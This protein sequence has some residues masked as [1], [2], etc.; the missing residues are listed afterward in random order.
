MSRPLV[1]MFSGQGSQY[2]QM[3]REL[4]ERQP[5]YRGWML[6]GEEVV[7][8]I[9]GRSILGELYSETRKKSDPFNQVVCTHPA[10]FMLGYALARTLLEGG[11]RPDYLLGAS[12]GELTALCVA[13]CLSFEETLTLITRQAEFLHQHRPAGG[14]MLAVFAPVS[15]YE[16]SRGIARRVTLCAVYF[17]EAFVV[18]GSAPLLD[19][20]EAELTAMSVLYQRLPITQ[21]FHSP[22]IDDMKGFYLGLVERTTLRPA[23]I[24]VISCA[25]AA[26]IRDAS[27]SHLWDIIRSPIRFQETIRQQEAAGSFDYV[28]LGPSGSLANFVKYN[29]QPGSQS[30]IHNL[31]TPFG[32][33]WRNLERLR[34]ELRARR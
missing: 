33:D 24:P 5:A 15:L 9:S 17:D 34:S 31:L 2:Y 29:L 13:G 23:S 19:Q 11:D 12:L 14:G 26:V 22:E 4:F 6:R 3:G 20:Y 7:R 10:L 1:F 27:P 18:S 28:D 25:S 8:S 16:K 21:G 30:H 32:Q